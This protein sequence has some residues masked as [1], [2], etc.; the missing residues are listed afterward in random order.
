M[1][2]PLAASLL[3]CGVLAVGAAPARATGT[4]VI[5]Q[6]NGNLKVYK[7]AFVRVK[8]YAMA[9]T[10]ADGNGMLVIGKAS[11]TQVGQ[12]LR[13]LPYDATLDQYGDTYHIPLASGTVWL[14]PT[15]Q[16]QS[17]PYSSARLQPRGVLMSV[18]TKAGTYVSLSGT[19]DEV[20][21]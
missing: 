5:Q 8:D 14:N 18:H 3:V 6:P 13:C 16:A 12:L 11:C 2:K 10:S 19:V 1:I 17:L 21:K 7:N 9:I 4:V 15:H 20:V